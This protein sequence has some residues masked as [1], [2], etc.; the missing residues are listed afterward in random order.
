MSASSTD[1][2]PLGLLGGTFDPVHVGHLRLAEEACEALQLAGVCLIPAGTPPHRPVPLASG[3]ERLAMVRLACA[4]NPRLTVEAFEVCSPDKSY[5]VHT[6][7]H[8]R[9]GLGPKRPLVLILGTDAFLG[10]PGW[11]R[12]RE[13]LGLAHIAVANRPGSTPD[14]RS[15]P[16]ALPAE[17]AE[18]A[19]GRIE[20][21]PAGLRRSPAGRIVP[22]EMTPL[23]ISA[24]LI[25]D[26]LR[27]GRSPR[28]LLP[29][30]V[31]DYIRRHHLYPGA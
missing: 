31:L 6:L 5:M 26:Q 2:G 20:S 12:W 8:L 14:A 22:F 29:D 24:S 19:D 25:R 4:G 21:D 11:H 28:Y 9:E 7:L 23:A 13:L 10:L 18:L 27:C 1:N 3:A 17:L 16:D 15:W 30:S